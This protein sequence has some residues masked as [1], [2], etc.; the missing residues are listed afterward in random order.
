M[1]QDNITYPQRKICPI[2]KGIKLDFFSVLDDHEL[3]IC[4]K[5][6][7]IFFDEAI[8]ERQLKEFYK[9]SY[10]DAHHQL[11]LQ[12]D[13]AKYYKDHYEELRKISGVSDGLDIF[14]YGCSFPIFLE[15]A[16]LL[17]ANVLGCDYDEGSVA[18]GEKV[19]IQVI[20]P[21]EF[22][23]IQKK[24][25]VI[26]FSHCLERLVDPLE[27]L[28][29]AVGLL[30]EN[31]FI[32][33]TQPLV[34]CF[35]LNLPQIDLE[36]AVFPSYLHVFNPV[37]I[38]Y[39]ARNAGLEIDEL[40]THGEDERRFKQYG[41]KCDYEYLSKY[42]ADLIGCINTYFGVFNN[43]P[44]YMGHNCNI[45]LRHS[46]K[47]QIPVIKNPFNL[48]A[49]LQNLKVQIL[50]KLFKRTKL[51]LEK[52]KDNKISQEVAGEVQGVD[53]ELFGKVILWELPIQYVA[54]D[55][56]SPGEVIF[57]IGGNT[58]GV[59]TAFS[60]LVGDT[61][62]VYTFE[63]NPEMYP[64]LLNTLSK[65]G[66]KNVTV[67][68]LAAFSN[69]SVLMSFYSDPSYF[70]AASGLKTSIS[71][72]KK[73][74]VLTISIDDFCRKNEINPAF[75]KIDVE[76]AEIDVLRSMSDLINGSPIPLVIEYQATQTIDLDDPLDFLAQF[77][78]IF[79][80]VNTYELVSSAQ[81]S[82]MLNFPRAN[83][84]CVG[85]D[86]AL[87][88]RYLNLRKKISFESA[89]LPNGTLN[90]DNINL[91]PGRYIVNVTFDCPD[92]LIATLVVRNSME[93]LACYQANGKQLREHSNSNIVIE[94]KY[95]QKISVELIK[96]SEFYAGLNSITVTHLDFSSEDK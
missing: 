88:T 26:R 50:D 64:R 58:G 63:P 29:I 46:K 12:N 52:I 32:Y 59:A 48:N 74:S 36:D 92:D 65:N 47:C 44:Y 27:V 77:G 78:Y 55:I 15:Q 25:D 68:P 66:I 95:S 33:I 22:F 11:S 28:K 5:C 79:F 6:R 80:D 2:C 14:D 56:V 37:S 41:E 1:R 42:S 35:K 18:Y 86:T 10:S 19:G 20:S 16:K 61:G 83:V 85:R 51:N 17:G 76:G 54:S 57:D 23:T 13:N 8:N 72:G 45:I 24:F 94:L 31:G 75:I 70:K 21:D 49:L 4:R 53:I 96:M 82:K 62:E 3:K 84:L 73:F 60:R 71:E 93:I 67:I 91:E 9:T 30:K 69:S 43:F 87:A 89:N 90:F 39:L 7:H 81:Y 38:L 40:F 34:P